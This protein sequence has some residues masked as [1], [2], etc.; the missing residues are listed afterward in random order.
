MQ[1]EVY[2]NLHKTKQNGR[3][4]YSIRSVHSGR[5][6]DYKEAVVLLNPEFRVSEAGRKRVIKE[7]RKNVH[8]VVRGDLDNSLEGLFSFPTK[9][10]SYNPYR[11]PFFFSTVDESPVSKGVKAILDKDGIFLWE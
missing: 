9:R 1:V 11:L 5:V 3:K 2:V 4:V 10:V 6:V 7:K 8:A